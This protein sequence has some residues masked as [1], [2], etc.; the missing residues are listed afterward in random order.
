MRGE[1]GERENKNRRDS[2]SPFSRERERTH[3]HSLLPH[4]RPSLPFFPCTKHPAMC[5]NREVSA[6]LAV[7]GSAAAW[8]QWKW[9]RPKGRIIFFAY[10]AFIECLQL[11]QYTVIDQCDNPLNKVSVCGGYWKLVLCFMSVVMALTWRAMWREL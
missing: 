6:V 2:L 5:W 7:A 3:T 1:R 11:A 9:G 10:W 4:T 8:T